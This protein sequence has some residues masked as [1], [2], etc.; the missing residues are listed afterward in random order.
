MVLLERVRRQARELC[1]RSRALVRAPLAMPVT[2]TAPAP[3]LLFTFAGRRLRAF[4]HAWRLW[5]RALC[6]ARRLRLRLRGLRRTLLPLGALLI[7]TSLAAWAL[8]AL[9]LSAVALV[10]PALAALL[11][12]TLAALL[13]AALAAAVLFAWPV[14]PVIASLVAALA[15]LA[16]LGTA[17]AL[18]LRL[19]TRLARSP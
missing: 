3:S 13:R 2:A 18:R 19:A 7:R 1:T 16:M 9:R 14:A 10:G 11:R 8:V 17:F 5:L 6:R 4:G 15:A 12:T